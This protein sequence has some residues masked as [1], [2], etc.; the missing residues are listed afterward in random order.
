MSDNLAAALTAYA[1][2]LRFS[3][4]NPELGSWSMAERTLGL[5]PSEVWDAE[6]TRSERYLWHVAYTLHVLDRIKGLTSDF[7]VSIE[8]HLKHH[9]KI[10]AEC[11]DSHWAKECS[12]GIGDIVKKVIADA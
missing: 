6:T 7:D 11:W 10:L 1:D 4:D 12:N 2:F 8:K 3:V 5:S 9:A